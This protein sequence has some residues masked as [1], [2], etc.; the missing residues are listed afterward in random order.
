MP[1]ALP[2]AFIPALAVYQHVA[3]S[4]CQ[5]PCFPWQSYPFCSHFPR[6]WM[7]IVSLVGSH[8][9]TISPWEYVPG[10]HVGDDRKN[11]SRTEPCTLPREGQVVPGAVCGPA[12]RCYPGCTV[13]SAAEQ[14]S[15]QLRTQEAAADMHLWRK[16]AAH[17]LDTT[18]VS[19]ET[20]LAFFSTP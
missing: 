15:Y 6:G 18:S 16:G 10:Q 8:C 20:L 1:Q 2:C 13:T 7:D 14:S 4:T 12:L 9:P 3:D 17:T 5:A 11:G 19:C